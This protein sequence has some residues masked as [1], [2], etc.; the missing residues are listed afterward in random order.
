MTHIQNSCIQAKTF[1]EPVAFLGMAFLAG[2]FVE[3]FPTANP[4]GLLLS[5]ASASVATTLYQCALHD[6]TRSDLTTLLLKGALIGLA[7]IGTGFAAKGL[8]GRA[9]I[10]FADAAK[11]GAAQFIV[12]VILTQATAP[13]A[14]QREHLTF[15]LNPRLWIRLTKEERTEKAKAFAGANLPALSLENA[16]I[17][18][19]DF[20][21]P[22]SLE[23]W[24][25]L[26]PGALSWTIAAHN[27]QDHDLLMPLFK[28][29]LDKGLQ[30]ILFQINDAAIS[31]FKDN[32][33]I[34]LLYNHMKAHPQYFYAHD[35]GSRKKMMEQLFPGKGEIPKV[36]ATISARQFATLPP[37]YNYLWMMVISDEKRW[38]EVPEANRLA[39]TKHMVLYS[40]KAIA[41]EMYQGLE[42][43]WLAEL[44]PKEIQ[45][46]NEHQAKVCHDLMSKHKETI[47]GDLSVEQLAAFNQKF[48]RFCWAQ[49]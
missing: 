24:E 13:S 44:T 30:P 37:F 35:E 36:N 26:S 22:A 38:G 46:L 21:Q 17:S 12:S 28:V 23:E 16:K 40:D 2:R 6:E 31:Y 29:Y 32:G 49:I 4:N 34:D 1:L 10:S 14:L 39:A 8:E 9:N 19:K 42:A 5:A 15:Q 47:K 20:P 3:Y 41:P 25:K 7:T 33:L 48:Q 43:K 11:M 27:I 45:A 18:K